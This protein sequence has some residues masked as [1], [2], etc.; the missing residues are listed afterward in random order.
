MW[1]EM[2]QKAKPAEQ[3]INFYVRIKGILLIIVLPW[4]NI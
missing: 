1:A 2:H 3:Q 4:G